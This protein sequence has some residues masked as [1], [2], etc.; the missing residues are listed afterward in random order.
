VSIDESDVPIRPL[1]LERSIVKLMRYDGRDC[2]VAGSSLPR[3]LRD[4]GGGVAQ[5]GDDDIG[6]EEIAH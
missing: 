6:V 4:P 3:A 5:Q 1:A 2:H